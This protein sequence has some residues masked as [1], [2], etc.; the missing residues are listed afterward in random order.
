MRSK[1]SKVLIYPVHPVHKTAR[2]RACARPQR[3]HPFLAP[4][5]AATPAASLASTPG[6]SVGLPRWARVLPQ[7]PTARR[8]A[9]G[10]GRAGASGF[11]EHGLMAARWRHP[12]PPCEDGL[13]FRRRKATLEKYQQR[14]PS[15][16]GRRFMVYAYFIVLCDCEGR[17]ARAKKENVLQHGCRVGGRKHKI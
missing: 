10:R 9:H 3:S 12:I 2:Q 7:D 8:G 4:L 17:Q 6:R 11:G 1:P 16:V 5:E 15:L 14:A 13:Q